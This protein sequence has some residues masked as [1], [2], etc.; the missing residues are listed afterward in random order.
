MR[1]VLPDYFEL[2]RQFWI[3]SLF[4]VEVRQA[5]PH[6]VFQ[7]ERADVVQARSPPIVFCQVLSHM[8][9]EKNVPCI[10]ALHYSLREVYTG[11]CY[12]HPLGH[13]DHAGDRS[14]VNAHSNL[15]ARVLF[16]RAADLKR[17]PRRFL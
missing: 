15:Q 9:R 2:A 16:K 11:S 13:V 4:R 17:T 5:H 6:T 8:M 7:L 1:A 10:T 12:I 14:T 3:T